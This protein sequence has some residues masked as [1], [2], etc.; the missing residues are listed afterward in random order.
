MLNDVLEALHAQGGSLGRAIVKSLTVDADRRMVTVHIITDRAFSPAEE[1]SAKRALRPF[2]PAYFELTA[3]IEKL[4]PDARMVE[5]KIADILAAS[6]KAVSATMSEGDIAAEKVSGGFSFVIRVL[7]MF[8]S[9]TEDIAAK[10]TDALSK[11]FCGSFEGKCEISSKSVDDLEVK[12]EVYEPSY[13]MPVRRFKIRNFSCIDSSAPIDTAVYMADMN[14]AEGTFSICGVIQDVQERTYTNK[15]GIDKPYYSYRLSDTTGQ[16]YVTVF[17]KT[18]S[19]NAVQSLKTGDSIVITGAFELKNGISRFNSSSIDKGMMPL[20]F[21][22]EERMS[23]PVPVAYHFVE[24]QPFADFEQ[25]DFFTDHSVPDCLKDNEFVVIDIETT[26]LNATPVGGRMDAIL[27]I[28][29][30]KVKG[31]NIC[32][33]FTT[34]VN[35]ERRISEEITKLTGITEEMVADAPTSSQVMP[36][37]FKFMYGCITVGHN[38]VNFDFNFLEHYC[39]EEGYILDRRMIDTVDLAREQIPGLNNYKLNTLADYF[40]ISFNHHRAVDDALVTAK[41]FIKLIKQRG[42]LPRLS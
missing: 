13:K 35:P 20:N 22:P 30:Y 18:R 17:P 12:R 29:A 2:V 19:L 32:E 5:K 11:S 9:Q 40:N 27:E 16:V 6:S 10:V 8:K 23:R 15:R 28:G 25:H 26:G 21:V 4:T 39:A 14:S 1:A 31:G 36:D 42:S 37:L 7:P 34:F 41:I 3:E 24:P 33:S 38:I